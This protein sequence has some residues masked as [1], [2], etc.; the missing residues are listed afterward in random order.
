M[1][2]KRGQLETE[3]T[4]ES[5]SERKKRLPENKDRYSSGSSDEDEDE[6]LLRPSKQ[7]AAAK[8]KKDDNL[9]VNVRTS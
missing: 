4:D 9:V 5:T 7:T 6:E 1:P 2:P 3:P 8:N